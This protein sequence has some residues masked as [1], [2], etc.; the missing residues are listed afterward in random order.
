MFPD[1]GKVRSVGNTQ[2]AQ[3][4]HEKDYCVICSQALLPGGRSWG[5]IID[6]TLGTTESSPLEREL[7]DF[8]LELD[9]FFHYWGVDL[10]LLTFKTATLLSF[11]VLSQ[12]ITEVTTLTPAHSKT[13]PW[14][15]TLN[16]PNVCT[17]GRGTKST[18]D[19]HNWRVKW[20][21]WTVPPPAS[22]CLASVC[23]SN[24]LFIC[25]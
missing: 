8:S 4:L 1:P 24:Y 13:E 23:L 7:V 14:V 18:S 2:A 3:C 20:S 5:F 6:F 17:Q 25:F 15:H 21:L 11:S 16:F 9:T 10:W 22:S 12:L 19:N